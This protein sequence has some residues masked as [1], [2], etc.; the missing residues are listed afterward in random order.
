MVSTVL[1][2]YIE[3]TAVLPG[4]PPRARIAGHRIRVSDIVILHLRLG[5]SLGEI[6]AR[7]G[8][9]MAPL[10]AAIAYYFDHK[11][12]ID[13]TIDEDRLFADAMRQKNPSLLAERLKQ[14]RG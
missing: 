2:R 11:D 10:Y 5:I 8:L 12:E 6:A 4:V 3:V 14:L 7:Y 13:R 9:D 1:D